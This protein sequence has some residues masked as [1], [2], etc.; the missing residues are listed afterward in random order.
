MIPKMVNT[1][2]TWVKNAIRANRFQDAAS[3]CSL[4]NTFTIAKK[5]PITSAPTATLN[6][7]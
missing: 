4:H 1:E 5:I 2:I 7:I 6:H 3:V